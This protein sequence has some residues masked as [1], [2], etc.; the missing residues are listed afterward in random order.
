MHLLRQVYGRGLEHVTHA[1]VTAGANPAI[2]IHKV[3]ALA[4]ETG[5]IAL[6]T[7]LGIE[8]PDEFR[9]EV[10]SGL[11]RNWSSTVAPPPG[12]CG[13][14]TLESIWEHESGNGLQIATQKGKLVSVSRKTEWAFYMIKEGTYT[15]MLFR[16]AVAAMHNVRIVL[17]DLETGDPD[18]P[19]A[20]IISPPAPTKTIRIFW[21]FNDESW[22][23]GQESKEGGPETEEGLGYVNL[24]HVHLNRYKSDNFVVNAMEHAEAVHVHKLKH[25][26][27]DE[28][29]FDALV[30][31]L[32]H[33]LSVRSSTPQ[34]HSVAS[35]KT[36]IRKYFKE[37]QE[38]YERAF[39]I[40]EAMQ[41]GMI[42]V[43]LNK[44][45]GKP[46]DFKAWLNW[47]L[48]G[49]YCVH[50]VM[51]QAVA[52]CFGSQIIVVKQHCTSEHA[53]FF[54]VNDFF[55]PP[56]VPNQVVVPLSWSRRIYLFWQP[57]GYDWGHTHICS[58]IDCP[59]PPE[60]VFF[61]APEIEAPG[62]VE[63]P[64]PHSSKAGAAAAS[65]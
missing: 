35:V 55:N 59:E 46:P 56:T 27:N 64:K 20:G 49:D 30:C 14:K 48:S 12:T 19:I 25:K 36:T 47:N 17:G 53:L 24:G 1:F 18:G 42:S 62:F 60:D 29:F 41:T 39:T 51:I 2:R 33:D 61:C 6:A 15:D 23:R 21:S 45:V 43:R 26:E 40:H 44:D 65:M 7:A 8:Q 63:A 31:A 50:S 32:N 13:Q 9:S 38:D 57:A 28:A 54:F 10:V 22:Y 34:L 37:N 58:G 4:S 5:P 52:S 11:R 16:C 3:S